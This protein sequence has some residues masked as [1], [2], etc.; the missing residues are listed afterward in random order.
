MRRTTECNDTIL[1]VDDQPDNLDVLLGY[2]H[3]F[4]LRIL[5][6][7]S[8]QEAL[9]ITQRFL[10]DVILLDVMMPPGINGFETCRRLKAQ[11]ATHDIPVIFMTA[12]VDLQDKI[13]GFAAGGVDYITKPLQH[14]EVF[15]RVQTH[16]TI[17]KQQRQLQDLNAAKDKFFSI[18]A[19][20]LRGPLHSLLELSVLSRFD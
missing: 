10:P 13:E 3:E 20:D 19:H 16:L 8:G 11:A 2:L 4:D 7:Q 14:E 12:L 1:V 17:R 15:A 6:A 5:V 9:N 18:I